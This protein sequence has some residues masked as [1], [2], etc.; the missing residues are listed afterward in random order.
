MS[1]FHPLRSLGERGVGVEVLR[2]FGADNPSVVECLVPHRSAAL[3]SLEKRWP[4]LVNGN[5]LEAL[6]RRVIAYEAC[7]AEF[8]SHA[9]TLPR[10][11]TAFH[12]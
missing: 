9:L 5:L 7:I 1:A 12:P 6:K 10:P 2:F 11:T 4:S 8:V 3:A